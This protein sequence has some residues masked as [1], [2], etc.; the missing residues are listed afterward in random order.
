VTQEREVTVMFTDI[1]GFTRLCE[2]MEP[3]AIGDLLNDYFGNMADIIFEHEGTLDK[4]IGDAILAVF[5]APFDQPD[6]AE[7]CVEAAL[8]MRAA[9]ARM[10]AARGGPPS[11]CASR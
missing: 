9:L 3:A 7:R 11:R 10:N 4:F 8:E 5:G 1:V 2:H 6:H